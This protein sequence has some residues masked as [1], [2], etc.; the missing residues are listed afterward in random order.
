MDST[1][2]ISQ[3]MIQEKASVYENSDVDEN[4]NAHNQ[5]N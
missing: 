3:Q 1:D 4:A 5:L 2:K